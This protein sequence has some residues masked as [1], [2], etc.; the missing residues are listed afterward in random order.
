MSLLVKA[1]EHCVGEL[2]RCCLRQHTWRLPTVLMRISNRF[3]KRLVLLQLAGVLCL[4]LH[5]HK[6]LWS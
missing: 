3:H 6:C 1:L 4:F 5:R 2:L